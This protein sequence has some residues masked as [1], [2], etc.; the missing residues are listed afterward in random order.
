MERRT[1]T[2]GAEEAGFLGGYAEGL[3]M[4]ARELESFSKE[5]PELAA[6]AGIEVPALEARHILGRGCPARVAAAGR[7]NGEAVVS[8]EDVEAVSRLEGVVTLASSRIGSC[9]ASMEAAESSGGM[10]QLGGLIGLATG[11]IG[12]VKAIF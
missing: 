5:D 9:L 11:A 12:L 2:L 8:A 7:G 1:I 4:S 6:L 10:N 3:E